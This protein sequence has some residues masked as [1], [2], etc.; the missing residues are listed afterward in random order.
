MGG[1]RCTGELKKIPR[2]EFQSRN[3]LQ[4]FGFD[5]NEKKRADR[6]VENNPFVDAWFPLIESNIT[7]KQCIDIVSKAGIDT[8]AMYKM[9][10]R[11]NNCIGCVKG[12]AGY[13]NKIRKDFPDVFDRMAKMERKIN[14]AICKSYAGDGKRKRIFLDELPEDMGR[15][16]D[17]DISCGLF[18]GEY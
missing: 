15:Y 8:P 10:Y 6:F 9:G 5:R 14:A 11:N 12:Q 7:K 16:S 2:L 4:V 13:W 17:L 1:A 3:D 18:C